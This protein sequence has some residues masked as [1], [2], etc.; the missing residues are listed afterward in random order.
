MIQYLAEVLRR[1]R[2]LPT[3]ELPVR[4][5][6]AAQEGHGV[7]LAQMEREH[8]EREHVRAQLERKVLEPEGQWSV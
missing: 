5:P 1:G 6:I 4:I 3:L 2:G 7:P 8:M